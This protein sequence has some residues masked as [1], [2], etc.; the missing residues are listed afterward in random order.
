MK[1]IKYVGFTS[2]LLLLTLVSGCTGT[3]STSNSSN[4]SAKP[5]DPNWQPG[6]NALADAKQPS[7]KNPAGELTELGMMRKSSGQNALPQK[8]QANIL[9]VP[10]EFL[11]ADEGSATENELITSEQR[12]E[13]EQAYFGASDSVKSFYDASSDEQLSLDGVVSPVVRLPKDFATYVLAAANQGN[14]AVISEIT[15]YIYQY[16]F[17]ETETYYSHDFDSDD[18]G[19]IDNLVIA[20]SWSYNSWI[21]NSSY[22][23]VLSS[24][25]SEST[26]LSPISKVNSMTWTTAKVDDEHD[27]K[28]YIKEVGRALGLDYYFDQTG[29]SDEDGEAKYRA[30][31]GGTDIMEGAEGK[32]HNSFSK[33]Q[34]G[35]INPEI[36]TPSD[37]TTDKELTLELGD[38]VILSYA[39]TGIFG[40]YL[41]L[42][43]TDSAG[44]KVYKVDSR[45]ARRNDGYYYPFIGET[46][47]TDSQ[48]TY[49]YSN[50]STNPLYTYGI[51][52][53]YAL[54]SLLS[55]KAD[56]RYMT[57]SAISFTDDDLFKAGDSFGT[58]S[59]IEGFYEDFRFDGDGSNGPKLGI[60]FTIDSIENNSAKITLRRAA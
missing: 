51:D 29:Y 60:I 10:V 44:V 26:Y 55:Q 52:Q 17:V 45:L 28:Q 4:S 25:F 56:N 27:Q 42:E 54:V 53:N 30:P 36:Y 15:D 11:I 49:A 9:V 58:E 57:D 5:Y 6:D 33:Y 13:L 23:D 40:E 31:L 48:Y 47:Y 24:F 19:K 7:V 14:D 41:M 35:W 12:E 8:G 16:L 34:L 39:Q 59:I 18:D 43:L 20:Y 38:S 46:E 2:F 37:L 32:D 22:D 3:S 21:L 1:N 50:S